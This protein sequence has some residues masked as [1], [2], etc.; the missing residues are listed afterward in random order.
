[1]RKIL[2]STLMGRTALMIILPL[3][4]LQI[5]MSVLIVQRYYDQVT[6]QLSGATINSLDQ[7][8]NLSKSREEYAKLITDWGYFIAPEVS[9]EGSK[10]SMFDLSGSFILQVFEE[11][12]GEEVWVQTRFG[13]DVK[14]VIPTK[15]G[16]QQILIYRSKLAPTNPHQILLN[17]FVFLVVSLVIVF[18][19]LRNQVRSIRRLARAAEAFG[20][21]EILDYFPT[22]ADEIRQAG[23]NF[24]KMRQRITRQREQRNLMLSGIS[25]DLRTPLTRFRLEVEMLDDEA[26]KGAL[27]KDVEE[28][29]AL[30][31]SFLDY[32]QSGATEEMEKIYLPD[33]LNEL[34]K[35]EDGLKLGDLA[36][37]Y[38][39][40]RPKMVSRAL[41]NLLENAKRYA[42]KIEIS[43]QVSGREVKIFV[44]D[45]GPGI[46]DEDREKAMLAFSR[47]DPSRNQNKGAHAGLGLAIAA[48][49]MRQQGGA[50]ELENAPLGGLRAVVKLPTVKA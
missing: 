10:V 5:S 33:F 15:F 8:E 12:Y 39:K 30:I 28:M 22:G 21:G 11:R 40:I 35:N 23:R 37:V 45:N 43:S 48:D 36:P 16:A 13:Q 9:M 3:L 49:A 14:V 29:D 27:L 44:D 26:V 47:L 24:I 31:T 4:V 25:H 19:F 34:A 50:L 17:T 46:S 42:Q 38:L 32:A 41:I 2:P 1:M 20:R 7:I 18:M 6:H